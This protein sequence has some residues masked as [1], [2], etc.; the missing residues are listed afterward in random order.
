METRP[1]TTVRLLIA[2]GFALSC[3]GLALFLWLAF[4][5]AI[6]LK[7]EGYRFTV[8]FDEATQLAVESDVR[9]SGVP[10]GKVK[11][12][13]LS[14]AGYADATIELD[15]AYSPIPS[16]TR[17]ILRQKTLLGETYVEL[18]PGD[19]NGPTLAEGG[20]LPPGQVSEAVQLDEIFRTFDPRTR[21]AFQAWM[22]GQAASLR[23]RGADLSVAIASLDPFAK[24]A[25]RLLRVLDSEDVALRQFIRDGG[26]TFAALA[27]Q[28]GQ[29]RGFIENA[30]QV[31]ETTAA[32]DRELEELFTVFPTF[33]RE[34]R[35]T[36]ARLERFATESDPTVQAL[37]PAAREL[38]PT[39]VE[40]E[41]LSPEL[42]SLFVALRGAID[43]APD[44][45]EATRE[46][47]DRDLPPLLE[48]F[49]PWLADFNSILDVVRMYRREVTSALANI[50]AATNGVFFDPTLATS[51]HYLRTEAAP[52]APEAISTYPG[53]LQVSR[54]NPY[55]RP[56]AYLDLPQGLQSFETSHCTAGL[57]ASLDPATPA[58]PAFNERTGGDLEEA[59]EFFDRLRLY[60]FNNM[61]STTSITPPPCTE[62]APFSS[63]GVPEEQ[64]DYLHV[65]EQP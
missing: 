42:N 20:E 6:P 35:E 55:F 14:D 44:G 5:G 63:V 54:T 49:D 48:A 38:E 53:R 64:S 15:S 7:P 46:L 8:P 21:A 17:A 12:V 30:A 19:A 36:L 23:G 45:F 51:I 59:Q 57:N 41:R 37:M 62:Q 61:L 27:E 29:L 52:L 13:D 10:V 9:I 50:A 26:Q 16:N 2:I 18:T 24:E 33:L 58:D 11:A 34:S 28:P 1:P 43:A 56:G 4:G 60:A 25:D 65:R 3:F 47:L 39:L 40:V 32:R 31:F 22:Q